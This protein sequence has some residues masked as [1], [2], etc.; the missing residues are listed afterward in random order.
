MAIPV[1][2][3]LCH[4]DVSGCHAGSR[5]A[6]LDVLERAILAVLCSVFDLDEA[7]RLA[8][9]IARLVRQAPAPGALPR[10]LKQSHPRLER[11]PVFRSLVRLVRWYVS[12]GDE[13]AET[14]ASATSPD[15]LVERTGL[16]PQV[17]SRL[18]LFAARQNVLPL[19][20]PL[21]R[22]AVRHGWVEW[23]PLEEELQQRLEGLDPD[24]VL[25]LYF[26]LRSVAAKYCGARAP[27]CDGCPLRPLLPPTGPYTP[28]HID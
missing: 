13:A 28:E 15:E 9:E 16:N 6:R 4:L 11:S 3:L 18:L 10:L 17:A 21:V 12:E 14:L 26:A 27:R 22:I 25:A 8:A 19:D 5:I 23:P 20:S 1:D 7:T 2:T 24:H